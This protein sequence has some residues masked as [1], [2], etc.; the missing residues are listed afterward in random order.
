MKCYRCGKKATQSGL[1]DVCAVNREYWEPIFG[2]EGDPYERDARVETI[3][4]RII[5][6]L[7]CAGLLYWLYYWTP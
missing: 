6:G 2:K 7:M 4:G 5:L 1:C 3:R